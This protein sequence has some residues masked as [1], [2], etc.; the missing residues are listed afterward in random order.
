MARLRPE[1]VELHQLASGIGCGAHEYD[2]LPR[3]WIE[4]LVTG[5]RHADN[6]KHSARGWPHQVPRETTTRTHEVCSKVKAVSWAHRSK[7]LPSM[8]LS[9]WSFQQQSQSRSVRPDLVVEAETVVTDDQPVTIGPAADVAD[10]ESGACEGIAPSR[11]VPL[12]PPCWSTGFVAPERGISAAF[13]AGETS[14]SDVSTGAGP[15]EEPSALTRE[16]RVLDEQSAVARKPKGT[17]AD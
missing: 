12:R 15:S 7:I 10:L 17:R 2:P 16:R 5:A 1:I 9:S 3:Y 11:A 8:S 13:N 4:D 14:R 6:L